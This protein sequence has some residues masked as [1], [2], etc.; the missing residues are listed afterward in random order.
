M[1]TKENSQEELTFIFWVLTIYCAYALCLTYIVLLKPFEKW[2][3]N[4]SSD[5]YFFLKFN[6][7]AA[8]GYPA[9][10]PSDARQTHPSTQHR[11]AA[12]ASAAVPGRGLHA[13]TRARLLW[14]L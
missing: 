10:A 1:Q 12:A 7:M 4:T 2:S 5:F 14:F 9:A 6:F 11:R 8:R 13:G 3:E